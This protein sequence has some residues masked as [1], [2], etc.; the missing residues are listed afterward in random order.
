MCVYS[1]YKTYFLSKQGNFSIYLWKIVRFFLFF[2]YKNN[3]TLADE[4]KYV[5]NNFW[6][7]I[8]CCVTSHMGE[9]NKDYIT[10]KEIL[11]LPQTKIQK[12]V[13]L[14]DYLASRKLIEINFEV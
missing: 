5:M 13:H 3:D 1:Q 9:W 2:I 11:P 8:K 6:Y 7:M 14:C 4:I 10:H 12:F